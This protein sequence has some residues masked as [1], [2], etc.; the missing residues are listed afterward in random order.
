M[1]LGSDAIKQALESGE[2]VCNAKPTVIE[3]THI[4]LHLGEYYYT[5]ANGAGGYVVNLNSADPDEE[6]TLFRG[7]VYIP[8]H[9]FVLAHTLEYA[10]TTTPD[11]VPFI[12]TRSTMA[13]WGITAHIS[14]GWGD[15]GF[16]GRWTLE[17]ANHRSSEV[18]IPTGTRICSI[19]FHQVLGNS[20]LYEGRYNAPENWKPELMLPRK[21]NL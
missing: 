14:A 4:D 8:A 12:E 9:G 17:I 2:I 18:M 6:Y 10:G 3:A 15:P 20:M 11:L 7:N 5:L 19:G 13:R 21:G 16:C 1:L